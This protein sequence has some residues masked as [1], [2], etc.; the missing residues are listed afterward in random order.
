MLFGFDGLQLVFLLLT[1]VAAGGVVLAVALPWLAPSRIE[2]RLRGEAGNAAGGRGSKSS[3]LAKATEEK[4][5]RRR[6]VQESLRQIEERQ[7]QK[8]KRASVRLLINR[9]GLNLTV[10]K[11]WVVSLLC[12]AVLGVLP[13]LVGLPWYVGILTAIVGFLGVPRWFLSSLAKKRQ[14]AFIEGLP[15][16]IDVIVRGLKAGLP[17]SDAMRVI[18]TEAVA[19]IGPEFM[20][21][22]E[23]QRVGIT[24]DQ[25]LERMFERIPLPE[26]SFLGIV[27]NI[28]SKT[29]GNLS[30]A[31]GNLSRV[32]RDRKK[33]KAKIRAVSQEAK[34]SAIII[35]ALPFFIIGALT[36]LSPAYITPLFTTSSGNII[37]ACIGVWMT[38][39]IL[40]MRQMINF[41]I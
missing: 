29:G 22:V 28:Q 27:I 37:L 18:A 31:L 13:L 8:S 24:I 21:V 23:G 5:N 40:V 17:I 12:G 6:R 39:G 9:S 16:A 19:P 35:G 36:F 15:D 14:Q 11:F 41:E 3:G 2:S 20:E 10:W 32:L 34:T 1:A 30:E 4:D 26:V 25:G 38:I 7:Q 33:M